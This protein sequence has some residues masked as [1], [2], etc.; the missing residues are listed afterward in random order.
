[1][2]ELDFEFNS[3]EY[4]K[5]CMKLIELCCVGF[6]GFFQEISSRLEKFENIVIDL[7]G[8]YNN[9]DF[10]EKNFMRYYTQGYNPISLEMYSWIPP[11][12]RGEY[13]IGENFK[14]SLLENIETLESLEPMRDQILQIYQDEMEILKKNKQEE[15]VSFY[16]R[17]F[18]E[19]YIRYASVHKTI[20][21]GSDEDFLKFFFSV[22]VLQED[23]FRDNFLRFYRKVFSVDKMFRI[24]YDANDDIERGSGILMFLKYSIPDELI[25]ISNPD[26]LFSDLVLV[27]MYNVLRGFRFTNKHDPEY[28]D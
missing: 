19:K 16:P 14:V 6:D 1:M 21:C 20:F 3:A 7:F 22:P 5:F 27:T 26:F 28:D 18:Y 8:V 12:K 2:I 15:I 25:G 9:G 13:R 10:R 4:K 23:I 17:I 11:Y 24:K